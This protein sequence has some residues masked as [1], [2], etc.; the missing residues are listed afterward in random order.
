[1]CC[2]GMDQA[3]TQVPRMRRKVKGMEAAPMMKTAITGVVVHNKFPE[4]GRTT[5]QQD[6]EMHFVW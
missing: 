2:A 4:A 6:L 5:R 3:K 1:M